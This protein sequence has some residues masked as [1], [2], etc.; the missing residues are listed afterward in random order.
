MKHY[1]IELSDN[2]IKVMTEIEFIK[3]NKELEEFDG[4]K[5][6]IVKNTFFKKPE[7]GANELKYFI[8]EWLEDDCDI[9]SENELNEIAYG[10]ININLQA[11]RKENERSFF[12]HNCTILETEMFMRNV[13]KMRQYQNLYFKEKTDIT[14]KSNYLKKSIEFEKKVDAFIKEKMAV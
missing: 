1:V 13:S 7:I 11:A 8:V 3:M 10:G 14:K 4:I 2:E 5:P 9:I 6:Y 12:V